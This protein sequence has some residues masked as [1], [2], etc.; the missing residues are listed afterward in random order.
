MTTIIND[1]D[2]QG[3]IIKGHGRDN[4]AYVFIEFDLRTS[5]NDINK[6]LAKTAH[7]VTTRSCQDCH[8]KNKENDPNTSHINI[9]LSVYLPHAADFG[10]NANDLTGEL[11]NSLGNYDNTPPIGFPEINSESYVILLVANKDLKILKDKVK[12]LVED[13]KKDEDYFRVTTFIISR[14]KGQEKHKGPL[15]FIDG[16]SNP[17]EEEAPFL[18]VA[19]YSAKGSIKKQYSTLFLMNFLA[20]RKHF[21]DW[22]KKIAAQVAPSIL[23]GEYPTDL[24][25]EI[26]A[27]IMGRFPD[28]RDLN[29]ECS[30]DLADIFNH[31]SA[32]KKCPMSAHIRS[33]HI[34]EDQK[35]IVRRGAA[36]V[37]SENDMKHGL[38]FASFQKNFTNQLFPILKR[39]KDNR[40][41]ITYSD[42]GASPKRNIHTLYLNYQGEVKEIEVNFSNF[43][44]VKSIGASLFIVP[45]KNYLLNLAD[46][47]NMTQ[48]V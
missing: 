38:M 33:A 10:I 9:A 37:L 6:W 25:L 35:R 29:G 7:N 8:Y 39:L 47:V 4:C 3:G 43:Q 21:E 36:Y 15:G 48:Q 16:I 34:V 26:K 44:P 17:S 11:R 23:P 32:F 18:T 24:L 12:D 19:E 27:K 45:G 31:D 41:L 5:L 2:F 1:K 42:G 20:D 22:V 13:L 46:K 30:T 28:G 14:K 40:D